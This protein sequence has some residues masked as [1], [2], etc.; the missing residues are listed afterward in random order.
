MTAPD[1]TSRVSFDPPHIFKL[2]GHIVEAADTIPTNVRELVDTYEETIEA[3]IR[4]ISKRDEIFHR[5]LFDRLPVT[6]FIARLALID[7]PLDA[8]DQAAENKNLILYTSFDALNDEYIE[9]WT[10]IEE[11]SFH[12]EVR[13][14]K[15]PPEFAGIWLGIRSKE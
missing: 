9:Y 15:F 7:R 5:T 10:R 2:D 1:N 4:D 12:P 11:T 13:R 6:I 14:I 3:Q 8:L